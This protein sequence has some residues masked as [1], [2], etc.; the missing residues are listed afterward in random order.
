MIC[1]QLSSN[2]IHR[3]I[4]PDFHPSSWISRCC[5]GTST[6]GYCPGGTE[7]QCCTQA[8]CT[9][10]Q[11][12]GTCLATSSCTGNGTSYAGYCTGPSDL[13]C[14]VQGDAPSP[15]PP[16]GSYDRSAALAYAEVSLSLNHYSSSVQISLSCSGGG[17]RAS[18]CTNDKEAVGDVLNTL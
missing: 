18:G 10:P 3:R 7:I 5:S 4:S 16:S 13:Q 11:G 8:T 2:S 15:S 1:F 17:V 12:S 14:C 9:T 6:A